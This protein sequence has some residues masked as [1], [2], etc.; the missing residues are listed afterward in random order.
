MEAKKRGRLCR[1]IFAGFFL[2]ALLVFTTAVSFGEEIRSIQ[3]DVVLQQDGSADITQVWDA[4]TSQGTEFYIPMTNMRD[5]QIQN[6]RVKDETGREYTF[7]ENWDINGSLE[8]KAFKNGINWTDQGLE[9]CWGKGSYGSHQYTLSY[10]MTNLVQAFPDNDGFITRFVNDQMSPS[11]NHVIVRISRAGVPAK[12]SFVAT[13]TGVWGFGYGGYINVLDGIIVAE[14]DQALRSQDHVTVMVRL[15]KNLLNPVSQGSGTFADMEQRALVG[16]DYTPDNDS[17]WPGY[18]DSSSSN[19]FGKTVMFFGA[20]L[21]TLM[22]FIVGLLFIVFIST[23]GNFGS[24]SKELLKDYKR[25]GGSVGGKNADYFRELPLG[26]HIGATDFALTNGGV[27]TTNE[28]LM[29][30]YILELVRSRALLVQKDVE[31]RAF[32]KDKE[33]VSLIL[34]SSDGVRDD[35]ALALY[36]IIKQAAGSDGILQENEMK[37]WARTNYKKVDDWL[38]AVRL[39][40]EKSFGDMGGYTNLSQK[41]MFGTKYFKQLTDKGF[42]MINNA[43]GFKKYLEDFT[44]IGERTAGEV[45][46]WDGYLV[47]A[48]LFGIAEQVA[49]EMERIYPE[50]VNVSQLHTGNSDVFTTLYVANSMNRAMSSGYNS[51]KYQSQGGSR[52][53]GGGGFSSFGGGGGFSGGGSGGGSR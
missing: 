9:L 5:M 17:S 34:Q 7:V 32:W 23:R 21:T 6:F 51:G 45:E 25:L 41:K 20:I 10:T 31:V 15:P 44:L 53:S 2:A 39:G 30:A 3:I 37:K 48:A 16:S 13:E 14:T 33:R 28:N 29:G 19:M 43:L 22:P 26:G 50:F 24:S 47:F 52:S 4:S 38:N 18:E 36:N 46:L 35:N 40:G 12:E 49:K 11:P 42:T 1:G 27:P 8:D